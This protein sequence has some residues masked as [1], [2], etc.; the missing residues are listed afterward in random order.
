MRKITLL[1]LI[2]FCVYLQAQEELILPFNATTLTEEQQNMNPTYLAYPTAMSDQIPIQYCG[3]PN[4]GEFTIN[5]NGDKVIFSP[6]NLQY[7]AAYGEHLCADGTTQ[8]GTWRFAE[9]QWDYVGDATQGNVYWN[10]EKCDNSMISSSYNG[11]IDLFGWGTSGWNSGAT[12]YQPWSTSTTDNDYYPGGSSNNNLIGA[13]YNADWGIYNQIGSIHAG[14]WRMLTYDEWSY[15]FGTRTNAANLRGQATVNGVKGFILLPDGWSAPAEITFTSGT[16]ILYYKNTYSLQQWNLMENAGAVFLPAGGMRNGV[17]L[18]SVQDLGGY[19]S[20][21]AYD[22]RIWGFFFD[23]YDVRV[24]LLGYRRYGNSVRLVQDVPKHPFSVAEDRR[25]IFSPGN[26]QYNAALGE[27][28]CADGT[29]Q[30]G[31]WRFAEHQY[32][33]V[34]D[35][36]QGNVYW[37]EEKCNNGL[38][39][40]TYDGWID[41]FSWGTSGW[42][43]GAVCYQ[44]W[45][46]STTFSDFYPCGSYTHNLTGTCAN[47]DWGVYNQIGDDPAGTWRTL[48]YNEWEYL[49]DTRTNAANLRG[50]ATVNSVTGFILLPD[51]WIAPIGITFTSG[52]DVGFDKNVYTL[53]QWTSMENL[54]AVFLPAARSRWNTIVDD[55]L[56]SYGSYWFATASNDNTSA[57]FFY[58]ETSETILNVVQRS[59]GQ[60]VRLVK[61]Y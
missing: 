42:N 56:F 60:S 41:L 40:E 14:T 61:D 10:G 11:W 31:T 44:P 38:I 13:Y 52:T 54:G 29:T 12:A 57:W 43:S 17:S 9:H 35:Y 22:D 36:S 30:P 33:Y 45:S 46:T 50:Q 8:P 23:S 26:L 53:Q 47:A 2:C 19:Y 24:D 7:N 21:T 59:D 37:N 48:T 49:F 32:D 51:D 28:L 6:G 25:V 55:V 18:Y 58:F 39:S 27:H 34:G 1:L 4:S 20:A 16:N 3:T 5:A 15:L